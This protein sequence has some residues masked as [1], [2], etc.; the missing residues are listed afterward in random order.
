MTKEVCWYCINLTL[1]WKAPNIN[2]HVNLKLK[3]LLRRLNTEF[4]QF[5]I[6]FENLWKRDHV[7]CNQ[8]H[9]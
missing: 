5:K 4:F 2:I 8:W 3:Q 6:L 1:M 9:D 7:E